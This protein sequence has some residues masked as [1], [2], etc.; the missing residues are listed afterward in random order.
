MYEILKEML[1]D[2]LKDIL[3]NNPPAVIGVGGLLL[4]CA[5]LPLLRSRVLPPAKL[6]TG[7][8][9][10]ARRPGRPARASRARPTRSADRPS[11]P[12]STCSA[13]DQKNG[14]EPLFGE[15]GMPFWSKNVVHV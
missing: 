15:S 6:P 14:P 7:R 2:I 5:N 12:G 9:G 3:L 4:S 13:P 11:R 10:G 1:K 8:P